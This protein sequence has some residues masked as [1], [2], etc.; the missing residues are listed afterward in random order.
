[1]N[2]QAIMKQAQAM[3]KEM[4]KAKEEID[5]MEFTGESSFV[6]VVVNGQKELLSVT[7]DPSV[8]L[9]KD[10]IEMLQDVLVVAVNNAF[11]K[12]DKMTEQKMGKFA[13]VPG[14]F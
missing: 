13:N 4:M 7:I 5:K 2:I 12:V 8:E 10:D 11:Q 1:M 9:S 14:M 3:Q 6:K